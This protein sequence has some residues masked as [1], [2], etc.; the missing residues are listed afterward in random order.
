MT[1]LLIS[2]ITGGRP[3]LTDRPTSRLLPLLSHLGDIEYVLREDHA[4]DYETDPLASLNVYPLAWANHYAR[5]HWRHPRAVFQ[6]DGFHGAFTG[7]EWA[8]QT[9][10]ERG[11]DLV[12]QLDDNI[13]Q[14]GPHN[15]S[16]IQKVT[17][18]GGMTRIMCEMAMS[19]NLYMLGMQLNSVGQN[20]SEKVVRVGYPYSYFLEKTGPGRMP[21]Y[22]PFEDDIMHALEY[23]LNGGP[24]RTVGIVPAFRY[25]KEHKAKTGMRKHCRS[26]LLPCPRCSDERSPLGR[27]MS[28]WT[29]SRRPGR[30]LSRPRPCPSSAARS[31]RRS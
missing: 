18:P 7:R 2:V 9:A 24:N 8:M 17:D 20:P 15:T 28:C 10:E 25:L 19:T 6:P 3:K 27:R 11:Y 12:L 16:L 22:G 29:A 21:F 13:M 14:V 4:P 26:A 30:P 31:M 1:R 23:G 5:T